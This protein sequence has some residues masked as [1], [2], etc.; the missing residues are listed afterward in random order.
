MATLLCLPLQCECQTDLHVKRNFKSDG[1]D[2][3]KVDIY[4]SKVYVHTHITSNA[5]HFNQAEEL[6]QIWI[7]TEMTSAI[8]LG[9][10]TLFP[11]SANPHT[12]LYTK[13]A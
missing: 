2:F 6:R 3:E 13:L 7:P 5:S 11:M 12:S 4:F 1:I 10:M 8:L 9:F